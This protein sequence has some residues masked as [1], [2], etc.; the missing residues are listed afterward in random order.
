MLLKW[1]VLTFQPEGLPLVFLVGQSA[2]KE[3][4]QVL[5]YLRMS[6]FLL[7]FYGGRGIS[8]QQWFLQTREREEEKNKILMWL[9]WLTIPGWQVYTG[10]EYLS[11]GLQS[12][13]LIGTPELWWEK[14]QMSMDE[15]LVLINKFGSICQNWYGKSHCIICIEY[16]ILKPFEFL[17]VVTPNKY[18]LSA[19]FLLL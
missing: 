3:F 1:N 16:Q 4:A 18:V 2:S 14:G 13:S 6:K 17:K 5:I 8:R 19:I 11:K 7:H 9:S 10:A 12:R 15:G